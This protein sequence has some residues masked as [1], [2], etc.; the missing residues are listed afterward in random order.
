MGA[1]S[2]RLLSM[3]IAKSC[4]KIFK[5]VLSQDPRPFYGLIREIF[6]ETLAP[7]TTHKFFS[8]LHQKGILRR[9]FW[10]LQNLVWSSGLFF[11]IYTQNIDALE[12]LAGVPP[13]KIIG[14]KVNCKIFDIIHKNMEIFD[15]IKIWR[16]PRQLPIGLLHPVRP[17]LW[18]QVFVCFKDVKLGS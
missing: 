7:T 4:A 10:S 15:N 6:P 18:P 2:D 3:E 16:G 8:L 1:S 17:N 9:Y 12:V 5:C 13:E 14:T 11:R